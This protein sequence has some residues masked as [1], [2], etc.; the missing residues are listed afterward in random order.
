MQQIP[1]GTDP[2]A[3]RERLRVMERSFC[4][5]LCDRLERISKKDYLRPSLP[6]RVI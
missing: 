4:T 6:L 1:T 2:A 3:T 5:S